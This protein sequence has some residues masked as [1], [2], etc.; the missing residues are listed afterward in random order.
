MSNPLFIEIK[1]AIFKWWEEN[2][3]Y[4]KSKNISGEVLKD[5]EDYLRI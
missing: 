3:E 5:N 2:N 4:L 1:E